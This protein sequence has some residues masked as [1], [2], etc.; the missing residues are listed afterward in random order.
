MPKLRAKVKLVDFIDRGKHHLDLGVLL[1]V[2]A[3]SVFGVIMVYSASFYSA[4]NLYGDHFFFAGK[5]LMGFVLG[6]AAMA[7]CYFMNF[8]VLAKIKIPAMVI[9]FAVLI[10]VFIP[11]IGIESFGAKRWIGF[12][13]FSFQASE[14]AKFC[15]VL[16]AAGY[17]AERK[18]KMGTL[19]GALPVLVVGGAT[20][21]L[22]LAEPN[23]SIT[24]CVGLVMLIM[25]FVGGM[26]LKHFAL[27]CVPAA[28]LVPILIIM[29]PY[30]LQRLAAF[31]DPWAT[32]QAEGFQLIQ[33]LYSL[34]S[35]GWFGVGLF[36]SRQK[37][38]FLPFSESDFIFSI[39]GEEFGLI[40]C[41]LLLLVFGVLIY[42]GFRIAMTSSTRFG[43]Y[44][45]CGITSVIMV[46][47]IIN[48]AVVTGSIPPTGLP[49]PFISAGGTSLVVFMAAG[50]VLLNIA[51]QNKNA[52]PF[53]RR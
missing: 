2:V 16:F 53:L 1:P 9:G 41:V 22:I 35:G 30:R 13:S 24:L 21:V 40:G 37:F 28:A 3:L 4:E 18:D 39:I 17:M 36:N 10:M 45:A 47:T 49:L 52:D 27:M 46:Q 50:G 31:L 14:I 33:S 23:L 29:E 34:G 12:G 20:C 43:S 7:G 11:G 26:K 6:L 51:R 8:Q 5:Q 15:F 25:L 38:S 32:P 19:W 44:L 42:S 48:I